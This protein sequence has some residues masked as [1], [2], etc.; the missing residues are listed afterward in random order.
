MRPFLEGHIVTRALRGIFGRSDVF[1]LLALAAWAGNALYALGPPGGWLKEYSPALVATAMIAFVILHGRR[2]YGGE[3]LWRFTLIVF[4]IA[5]VFE[6]ISVLTGF[7]FGR[8]HYTEVMA[9]FLWHV[10]VFVLPAY[11]LMAYLSWSLAT[12]ILGRRGPRPDRLALMAVPVLAA[13]AMVTWDLSMDILRATV[14][15]RWIWIDGGPH[16]GVPISNYLGWFGV[17]W[18]MFQGFA[19]YL[20]HRTPKGW[21]KAP[22]ERLFWL[23]VPLAYAAFAGEYL[24]NPLGGQAGGLVAQVNGGDVAVETLFAG[25]AQVCLFTMVP[26]ALAGVWAALRPKGVPVKGAVS[27]ARGRMG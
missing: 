1:I 22:E 19:F 24:L 17:T 6:T 12:L 21:P 14:E 15:R 23:S 11:L 7:P 5:W 16:F 8:Y 9:P 26:L 25:A 2:R 4:A 10:P 18:L 27:P 13:A 3:A 20:R